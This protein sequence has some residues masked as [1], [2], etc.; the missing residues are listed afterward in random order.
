M[1]K[2]FILL[3]LILLVQLAHTASAEMIYLKS[4]EVIR[5]KIIRITPVFVRIEKRIEDTRRE[6][7]VEDIEKITHDPTVE[8]QISGLAIQNLNLKANSL[9]QKELRDAAMDKAVQLIQD[10]LKNLEMG[11]LKAGTSNVNSVVQEK[12]AALI[13]ETIKQ[14]NV[15]RLDQA[16]DAIK[17][18]ALEVANTLIEE[19]MKNTQVQQIDKLSQ[20]VQVSAQ[21]QISAIVEEAVKNAEDEVKKVVSEKV[22]AIAHQQV[23]QATQEVTKMVDEIS[24]ASSGVSEQP[25]TPAA[26]SVEASLP[27]HAQTETVPAPQDIPQ[28]PIETGPASKNIAPKEAAA[29]SEAIVETQQ[30]PTP[31]NYEEALARV[32]TA[33]VAPESQAVVQVEGAPNSTEV[34]ISQPA[35]EKSPTP[36]IKT[37]GTKSE[38]S[39]S[40]ALEKPPYETGAPLDGANAE[41]VQAPEEKVPNKKTFPIKMKWIVIVIVVS[42]LPLFLR[43]KSTSP[44]PGMSGAKTGDIKVITSFI[45]SYL[46]DDL[47]AKL[48]QENISLIVEYEIQARKEHSAENPTKEKVSQYVYEKIKD[49][50]PLLVAADIDKVLEIKEKFAK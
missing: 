48:T 3:V 33:A 15:E 42:L 47:G 9:T 34:A 41:T 17:S 1:R 7:L 31:A 50:M 43:R 22:Q 18:V 32:E 20:N 45:Y 6:F 25:S 23:T 37:E 30:E 29:S 46:P 8:D 10:A 21:E 13:A 36:Q 12:A 38:L 28:A 40:A 39:E 2:S 35:S 24:V 16:P 11:A 26:N 4:G 19:A 44:A 49:L 5:G 27:H 14:A